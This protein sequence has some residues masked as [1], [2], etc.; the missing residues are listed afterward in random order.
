M[1]GE[2]GEHEAVLAAR[3]RVPEHVVARGFG[4]ESVALNLRSGKY[5][6]LNE[7][8]AHM[9]DRVRESPTVGAAV[10]PLAS[11]FGQ[12]REV[13][14]RDLVALVRGLAE[15][16]LVELDAATGD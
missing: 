16:G 12:P 3:A 2:S 7:V 13:I 4:G 5:H 11:E 15:R 14:E 8:A 1:G 6:G 10:E 9:L